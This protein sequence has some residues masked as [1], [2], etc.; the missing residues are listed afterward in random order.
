MR[1]ARIKRTVVSG[2]MLAL[3]IVLPLL[4]AGA[5]QLGRTLLLM[6]LPVMLCGFICGGAH[7]FVIGFLCP[8]L[9]Y[10]V[11]GTPVIFPDGI[12]MA[13]ELGTYGFCCGILYGALPKKLPYTYL[14]L[15]ISMIVGRVIWGIVRYR[16]SIM[17]ETVFGMEAFIAGSFTNAI[18][19]IV[20]QIALLPVLVT[21]LQKFRLNFNN[22]K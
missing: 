18:P 6:H 14:S 16:L 3:G 20:M 4:T 9:R 7:G 8:L 1:D 21:L 17:S 15:I 10:L 5:P 2:L 13:F 12:A 19:G 22:G 11:L